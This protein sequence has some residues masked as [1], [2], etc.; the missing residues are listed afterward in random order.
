M[1]TTVRWIALVAVCVL[2]P[3][4]P[5]HAVCLFG[6]GSCQ[7][8]A[9]TA[10]VKSPDGRSCFDVIRGF[11]LKSGPVRPDGFQSQYSTYLKQDAHGRFIADGQKNEKGYVVR[12]NEPHTI[13]FRTT[14]GVTL[15]SVRVSCTVNSDRDLPEDFTKPIC[16]QSVL[17][18]SSCNVETV[19]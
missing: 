14:A 12:G 13:I 1:K 17:P 19:R 6:F 3:S 8:P 11:D 10:A 16:E 7:E 2:A 9:G 18:S 5:A 4:M 15:A